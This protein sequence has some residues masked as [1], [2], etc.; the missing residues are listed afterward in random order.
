MGHYPS[1]KARFGHSFVGG[2]DLRAQEA[3]GVSSALGVE[4]ILHGGGW[5][6]C[7]MCK[8]NGLQVPNSLLAVLMSLTACACVLVRWRLVANV[9]A[10]SFDAP[11]YFDSF[12]LQTILEQDNA[13]MCIPFK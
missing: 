3:C 13:C 4:G 9:D 12:P 5:Q 7:D 6:R 1:R 8:R 2:D 10:L 11:P